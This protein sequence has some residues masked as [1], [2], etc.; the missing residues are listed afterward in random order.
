MRK[1]DR[2]VAVVVAAVAGLSA[3]KNPFTTSG[4]LYNDLQQYRKAEAAF[5]RALEDNPKDS[6]ALFNLARTVAFRA[7]E[8]LKNSAR[9][10]DEIRRD[11]NLQ[12]DKNLVGRLDDPAAFRAACFDSAKVLYSMA[13]EF[14]NKA[15]VVDSLTYGKLAHDNIQSNYSHA[16]NR[17]VALKDQDRWDESARYFELAYAVDSSGE[18]GLRARRPIVQV[19]LKLAQNELQAAKTD[20][21]NAAQAR[22]EARVDGAVK[23]LDDMIA[24]SSDPKAKRSLVDDKIKAL[25]MV[26]RTAEAE[27]LREG[28]LAE[29]PDDLELIYA[30]AN[31]RMSANK[32][33]EAADLY[34]R[35]VV[36]IEK[37]PGLNESGLYDDLYYLLGLSRFQTGTPDGYRA[38]IPACEKALALAKTKDTK[39][40]VVE[41]LALSNF[42][43]EQYAPAIEYA[44]Q[45]VELVPANQRAWAVLCRAY[46]RNNQPKE[47]EEACKRYEEL[48]GSQPGS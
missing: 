14:Y 8:D 34:Q 13:T 9:T 40:D 7:E 48:K 10:D 5:R 31:E 46:T 36:Q 24:H 19:Q 3:C 11:R 1:S 37:D 47:A 25:R 2:M 44:K 20:T 23:I 42:E 29:N 43:L 33:A 16:F 45:L 4:L 21:D 27:A 15:A 22:A 26:G 38:A 32:F 18:N 35:G 30:I 12:K 28:L 17:A 41:T 6:E 39:T